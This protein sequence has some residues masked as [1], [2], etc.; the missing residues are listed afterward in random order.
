MVDIR[1]I[2][3]M[4][5]M[6]LSEL[7]V[8]APCPLY[9]PSGRRCQHPLAATH[10]S[11]QTRWPEPGYHS[12]GLGKRKVLRTECCSS[13]LTRPG[14]PGQKRYPAGTSTSTNVRLTEAE[15]YAVSMA[16]RTTVGSH[17]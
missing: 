9:A 10:R 1:K 15:V 7:G 17:R 2:I 12:A 8:A 11:I 14:K 4:R 13:P 3:T 6:V 5:E 16:C